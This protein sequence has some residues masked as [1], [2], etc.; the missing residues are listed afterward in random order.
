[1]LIN[2]YCSYNAKAE[3]VLGLEFSTFGAR[4]KF[5]GIMKLAGCPLMHGIMDIL[6]VE[7]CRKI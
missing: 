1:M 2:V 4:G 6:L 5:F 3:R 7:K